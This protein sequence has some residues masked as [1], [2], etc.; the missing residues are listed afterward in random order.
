MLAGRPVAG[1]AR[2]GHRTLG[3]LLEAAQALADAGVAGG[4]PGGQRDD[5]QERRG[6]AARLVV[7]LGDLGVGHPALA[8]RDGELLVHRLGGVADRGD[9]DDREH[10]PDGDDET[11]VAE[12]PASQLFH[13]KV[14]IRKNWQGVESVV[15]E[16]LSR[17]ARRRLCPSTPAFLM[18]W[19]ANR[20][21]Q[22]FARRLE[23][24]LGLHPREF[25][26]LNVLE[27]NP[28][29]TQQAI[30]EHAGVDPKHDGRHA[31]RAGGA[32][33]RGAAATPRRPPQALR[34]AHP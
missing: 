13:K 12:N 28:G 4:L 15:K 18:N 2:S 11:A 17:I 32:R 5:G 26:V 22:Y 1:H 33:A 25:G 20:S 34:A 7:E 14:C 29:I 24:E 31:R 16:C 9:A 27:R 30:G 23:E 3:A 21:R 8:A 10:D 6:V 19:V